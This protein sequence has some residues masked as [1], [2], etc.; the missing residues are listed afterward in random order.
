MHLH[1]TCSFMSIVISISSL[2]LADAQAQDFGEWRALT[3]E[4]EKA[5]IGDMPMTSID[6]SMIKADFDGDRR[7]DTALIAVREGDQTRDLIIK[8]NDQIHVLVRSSESGVTV[9]PED[10]LRLAKAT[11]WDTICGNAFRELQGGL[12]ESE[13]YPKAVTLRNPGL[14][15]ISSGETVL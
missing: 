4:E 5:R 10:G 8:M 7:I 2:W 13:K 15:R 9:G 14:L 12:C 1:V 3:A 11:R 6:S